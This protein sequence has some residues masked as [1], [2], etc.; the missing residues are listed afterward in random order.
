[1]RRFL[2]PKAMWPAVT[3]ATKVVE[4]ARRHDLG[5]LAAG[6]AF[7]SFLALIPTVLLVILTYGLIAEPE[8]LFVGLADL[9]G[10]RK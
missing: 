8:S 7:Y 2:V 4:Q 5:Y 10:G 1:M 9:E 3:L 6:L